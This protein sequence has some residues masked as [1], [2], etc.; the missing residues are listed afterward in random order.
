MPPYQWCI[1]AVPWLRR[2]VTRLSQRRPGFATGSIHVGFVVD[3]VAMGQVFLRVLC[4]F[5]KISQSINQSINQS[6]SQSMVYKHPSL[7]A[8]N[9]FQK[10]QSTKWNS[11]N[12]VTQKGKRSGTKISNMILHYHGFRQE[13]YSETALSEAHYSGDTCIYLYHCLLFL[14]HCVVSV[15]INYVWVIIRWVCINM[16]LLFMWYTLSA[17]CCAGHYIWCFDMKLCMW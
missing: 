12:G 6:I 9:W 13:R 10:K 2:L 4:F 11:I 3:K 1:S 16:K 7:S 5:F 15:E 17:S 8:V 14:S